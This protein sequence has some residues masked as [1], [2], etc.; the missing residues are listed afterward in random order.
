MLT[1]RCQATDHNGSD[2]QWPSQPRLL[3]RI[4]LLVIVLWF[5]VSVQ[6]A[7]LSGRIE[8]TDRSDRSQTAEYLIVYYRP[9][10]TVDLTAHQSTAV[11]QTRNKNFEPRVLP[12]TAGSTVEF[13]NLDPILHNVFSNSGQNG[14]DAGLYSEGPGASQRFDSPGLVRV[15]CNVHQNMV[16]HI[17]VLDSPY[18]TVADATGSWQLN[19]LPEGSGT[20]YAWHERARPVIQQVEVHGDSEIDL[21]VVLSKP[22]RP[23]HKN[24]FG[25]SYRDR[26]RQRGRY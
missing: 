12:V 23:A 2:L 9:D 16:G 14:F 6:A 15:Y 5:C 20:L 19:D 11:M 17:L 3:P 1:M 18:Y 10:D 24:K 7:S 13:P 4:T 22:V 8:V 21:S 25:K 26:R